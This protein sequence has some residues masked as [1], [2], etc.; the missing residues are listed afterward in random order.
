MRLTAKELHRV[1]LSVERVQPYGADEWVKQT[2]TQLG[3]VHSIRPQSLPRKESQARPTILRNSVHPG[4][5]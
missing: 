3:S 1:R 2:E 5:E 4:R